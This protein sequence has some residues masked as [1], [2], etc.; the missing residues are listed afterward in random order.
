MKAGE[1]EIFQTPRNGVRYEYIG[2][3]YQERIYNGLELKCNGARASKARFLSI[4]VMEAD[5]NADMLVSG[6]H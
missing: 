2:S 5:G 4:H 6:C 1:H 3:A